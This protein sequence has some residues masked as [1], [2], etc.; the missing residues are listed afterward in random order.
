MNVAD[1]RN[2]IDDGLVLQ[3]E[4][5]MHGLGKDGV[6]RSERDDGAFTHCRPPCPSRSALRQRADHREL[7]GHLVELPLEIQV[8]A[9]NV[10]TEEIVRF[11]LEDEGCGIELGYRG[12]G[13]AV[14]NVHGQ[15]SEAAVNGIGCDEGIEQLAGI[16]ER[17]RADLHETVITLLEVGNRFEERIEFHGLKHV[18]LK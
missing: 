18:G 3:D 13:H 10:D 6:L 7:L 2:G 17:R 4:V 14:G 1:A 9:V 11:V 12:N 5:Q 8:D 16:L 15:T